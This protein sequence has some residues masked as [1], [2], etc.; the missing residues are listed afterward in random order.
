MKRR[1]SVGDKPPQEAVEDSAGLKKSKVDEKEKEKEVETSEKRHPSSP[2]SSKHRPAPHRKCVLR[3]GHAAPPF[4]AE[5]VAY[6]SFASFSLSQFSGQYV[7]LVFYPLDFTFVCPT[8][9]LKFNEKQSEFQELNTVV[10]GI[11]VDSKYSHLAWINTP[12]EQGGL[13]GEDPF[14]LPLLSDLSHSISRAYGVL[15]EEAGYSNRCIVII[16][17]KGI[18]REIIAND[19]PVGR[20]CEEIIRLINAFQHT[21]SHP[22]EVCPIDWNTGGLTIKASPQD[23]KEFFS[24]N[25]M[26]V[27]KFE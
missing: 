14:T 5:G 1:R 27:E 24:A 19:D 16:S 10:L 18:V 15:N 7:V 23:S 22:G 4:D 2:S 12:R 25:E 20:N 9:L 26:D 6:G 13:G 8:E 21:D 3:V 11:S 17:D